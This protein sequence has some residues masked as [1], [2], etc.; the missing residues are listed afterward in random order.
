MSSPTLLRPPSFTAAE[1][2][3]GAKPQY[4]VINPMHIINLQ[5]RTRTF[6]VR[7]VEKIK[8]FSER[9]F[10]HVLLLIFLMI[11]AAVGAL[12]FQWVEAPLEIREKQSIIRMRE[13]IA[14]NLLQYRNLSD[15]AWLEKA[16]ERLYVYELQLQ[17]HELSKAPDDSEKIVWTFWGSLFYAGTI[18]TTIGNDVPQAPEIFTSVC[19][20]L[21]T[22][23]AVETQETVQKPKTVESSDPP[24]ALSNQFSALAGAGNTNLDQTS[25]PVA[26]KVTP[27]IMLKYQSNYNL[28]LQEIQRTYLTSTNKLTGEY[29]KINA[30][31]LDDHRLIT[32][33]LT[34]KKEQYYLIS[35]RPLKIVLQGLP[36]STDTQ[37][38]KT[39]LENQGYIIEKVTQLTKSRTKFKL[40][41]FM[42]ELKKS[43]NTPDNKDLKT[44]CY[45]MITVD[46]FR[47]R[48]GANQCYNCNFFHHSSKNCHINMRCQKCGKPHKTNECPIKEKKSQ[49][50]PA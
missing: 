21:E 31:T 27:S 34:S 36:I 45:M 10:T 6:G 50:R 25:V 43:P 42:V 33:Y 4:V 17:E 26:V 44:C 1:W 35:L 9:W 39:D 23:L 19:E 48:P 49:T 15:A 37:E 11:Y 12:L 16:Y 46:S 29:I 22:R 32:D 5:D 18:F 24:S 8:A 2:P 14:Q 7:V 40:P 38:I 30:A 13:L 47:K 28:I 41:I 3:A 20:P